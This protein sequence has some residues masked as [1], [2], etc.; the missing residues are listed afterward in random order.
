M[1]KA[2]LL[3]P[4]ALAAFLPLLPGAPAAKPFKPTNLPFNTAADEDDPH[5]ADSGLTLFYSAT[6]GVKDDIMFV[7]RRSMS[8]SRMRLPVCGSLR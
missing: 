5:L 8:R 6:K 7:S 4:L 1:H 3:L 2:S